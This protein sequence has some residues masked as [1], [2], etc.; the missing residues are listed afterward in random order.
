MDWV[1]HGDGV[2]VEPV[3]NDDDLGLVEAVE[4]FPVAGGGILDGG[5]GLAAYADMLASVSDPGALP[6]ADIDSPFGAYFSGAP[7]AVDLASFPA[8]VPMLGRDYTHQAI[9]LEAGLKGCISFTK[10][11]FP[12]QEIMARI[13]NLGHPARLIVGITAESGDQELGGRI[14]YG[15]R[16]DGTWTEVGSVGGGLAASIR[17]QRMSHRDAETQRDPWDEARDTPKPIPGHPGP[18]HG[19]AKACAMVRWDWRVANTV[20][21]LGESAGP[22]V[23]VLGPVEKYPP[24]D[25]GE[26]G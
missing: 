19:T 7:V 26:K 13:E 12:G 8:S 2:V 4:D 24:Q 15:Q 3:L 25:A 6:R 5:L 14:L 20:L 22:K 9:A 16:P 21:A 11:C 1:E 17:G 10:G 23:L 18:D